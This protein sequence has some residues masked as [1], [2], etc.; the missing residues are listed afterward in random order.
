MVIGGVVIA[1]VSPEHAGRRDHSVSV[2]GGSAEP[3]VSTL[4]AHATLWAARVCLPELA[5]PFVE[6][7]ADE[8]YGERLM[9]AVCEVVDLIC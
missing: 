9:L 4:D 6:Y 7:E 1:S 2:K 3:H 8:L 5:L